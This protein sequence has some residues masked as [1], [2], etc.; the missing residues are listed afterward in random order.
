M[1]GQTFLWREIWMI[2]TALEIWKKI[3]KICFTPYELPWFPPFL[4]L[5]KK[6][7]YPMLGYNDDLTWVYII[8]KSSVIKKSTQVSKPV[9]IPEILFGQA[10]HVII[11]YCP[12]PYYRLLDWFQPFFVKL[13]FC[14][15][16][17]GQKFGQKF[18]RFRTKFPKVDPIWKIPRM[19]YFAKIPLF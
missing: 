2:L 5:I 6:S 4:T 17:C 11:A 10:G 9:D 8:C 16:F 18:R 12:S 14:A 15:K 3:L 19:K 13:L 1:T 7:A